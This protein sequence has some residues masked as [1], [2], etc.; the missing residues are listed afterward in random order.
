MAGSW[1]CTCRNS[2]S[3]CCWYQF[4]R[5]IGTKPI[6][7]KAL[8]LAGLQ[9]C[10]GREISLCFTSLRIHSS[11]AGVKKPSCLL[12]SAPHY[13]I[14]WPSRLRS[15]DLV[16]GRAGQ[17]GLRKLCQAALPKQRWF[18]C[19]RIFFSSFPLTKIPVCHL[20]LAYGFGLIRFY[21]HKL[22]KNIV[23]KQAIQK[24]G[25]ITN[26]QRNGKERNAWC[27]PGVVPHEVSGG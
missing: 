4:I 17:G 5:F 9:A 6:T 10:S 23:K 25:Y 24:M 13:T 1:I 16:L 3:T 14:S 21:H 11:L 2:S 19:S 27:S 20:R 12:T 26:L 7:A 22:S 8:D 15:A 18:C